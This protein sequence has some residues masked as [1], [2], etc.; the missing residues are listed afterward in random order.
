LNILGTEEM[1][2]TSPVTRARSTRGLSAGTTPSPPPSTQS[3]DDEE[4]E[5]DTSST[6]SGRRKPRH[7]KLMNYTPELSVVQEDSES[8]PAAAVSMRRRSLR[9]ASRSPSRQLVAP[10]PSTS[11]QSSPLKR[12]GSENEEE[13][14]A[15]TKGR[16][17]VRR[18]LSRAGSKDKDSDEE[19]PAEEQKKSKPKKR[20][21]K[22][23]TAKKEAEEGDGNDSDGSTVSNVS[24]MTSSRSGRSRT[25]SKNIP[26]KGRMATRSTPNPE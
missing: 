24:S 11:S 7:L 23:V 2:K 15:K 17:R 16:K 4:E 9:S 22:N 18:V 14:G 8:T 20:L 26:R 3:Y 12:R 19:E 6:S 10:L 13:T 5:E 21:K 1:Q 25:N